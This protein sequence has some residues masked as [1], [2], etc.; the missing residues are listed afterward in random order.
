M[1]VVQYSKF[2]EEHG[3]L[4]LILQSVP[5]NVTYLLCWFC[6]WPI[7]PQKTL[8]TQEVSQFQG[9]NSLADTLEFKH[10][11]FMHS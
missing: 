7:H 2:S 5:A 9:S 8:L 10:D 4:G 3:T 1:I 11:K 6:Q